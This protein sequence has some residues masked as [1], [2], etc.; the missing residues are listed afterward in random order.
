MRDPVEALS[1]V[2]LKEGNQYKL[3]VTP[4]TKS[5]HIH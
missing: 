2:G 1:S 5:V 4:I 3:L